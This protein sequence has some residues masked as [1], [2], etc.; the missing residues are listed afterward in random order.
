MHHHWYT[1]P[2]FWIVLVP[3]VW[4]LTF[5]LSWYLLGLGV[6]TPHRG[7]NRL[8]PRKQVTRAPL[9][10]RLPVS[11]ADRFANAWGF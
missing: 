2:L 8:A 6:G 1:N 7:Y 3:T 4:A 11:P 10:A 9:A 5:T